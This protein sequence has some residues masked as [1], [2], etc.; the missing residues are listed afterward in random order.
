MTSVW[1]SRCGASVEWWPLRNRWASKL[2]DTDSADAW[3]FICPNRTSTDPYHRAVH[4]AD[5]DPLNPPGP[6]GP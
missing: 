3:T 5:A 2:I 1:C 4:P 6:Q